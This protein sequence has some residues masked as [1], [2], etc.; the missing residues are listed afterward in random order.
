MV[1]VQLAH[2]DSFQLEEHRHNVL[3]ALQDVLAVPLL[4]VQT[5]LMRLV[6]YAVLTMDLLMDHV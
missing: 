6:Q 1:L 5:Q 4:M 2:Q 3:I